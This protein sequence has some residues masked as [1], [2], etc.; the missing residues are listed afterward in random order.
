[1]KFGLAGNSGGSKSNQL[2]VLYRR[3]SRKPSGLQCKFSFLSARLGS[4]RVS[5][6]PTGVRRIPIRRLCPGQI[7]RPSCRPV[8]PVTTTTTTARGFEFCSRCR[9]NWSRPSRRRQQVGCIQSISFG[10]NTFATRSQRSA[11]SSLLAVPL[12]PLVPLRPAGRQVQ[13][14]QDSARAKVL[15]FALASR[16]D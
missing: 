12:E 1:M 11:A 2:S 13:F 9:R 7:S 14:G 4:A 5:L 10:R 16:P 15:G 3:L 6:K 8:E